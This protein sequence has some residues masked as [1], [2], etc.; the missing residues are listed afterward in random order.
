[1]PSVSKAQARLMAAAAHNPEIA[2][3]TGVDPKVAKE[4]NEKDKK[5]KTKDKKLPEHK[6][7]S[8]ETYVTTASLSGPRGFKDQ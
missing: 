7:P 4:W 1:M 8:N 5:A 6:K 3:K 2:K